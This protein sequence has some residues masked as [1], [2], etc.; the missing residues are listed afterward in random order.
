MERGPE[1]RRAVKAEVARKR[2]AS[3]TKKAKRKY[4]NLSEDEGVDDEPS[5]K[6]GDNEGIV[7]AGR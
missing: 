1:S 7:E 6:A 5:T 3:K 4:R 2:K